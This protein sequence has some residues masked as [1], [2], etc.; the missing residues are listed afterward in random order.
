[1]FYLIRDI[2]RELLQFMADQI[3]LYSYHNILCSVQEH[4]ETQAR[5]SYGLLK[6]EPKHKQ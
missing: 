5:I 1:M 3:T 4:A 2:L 6:M